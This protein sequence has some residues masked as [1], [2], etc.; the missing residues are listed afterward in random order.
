MMPAH[1]AGVATVVWKIYL[2]IYLLFAIH[3]FA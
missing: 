3:E 2:A 1:K